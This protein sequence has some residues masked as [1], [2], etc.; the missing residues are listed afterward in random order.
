MVKL[1]ETNPTRWLKLAGE[2][3]APGTARP[4]AG[5]A[6][7]KKSRINSMNLKQKVNAPIVIRRDHLDTGSVLQQKQ[8]P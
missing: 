1:S 2:K 7:R 5:S 8:K 6:R 3:I 4:Y